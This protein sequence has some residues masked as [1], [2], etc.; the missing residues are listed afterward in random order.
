M[1]FTLAI[2]QLS[3]S[4]E[5][6]IRDAIEMIVQ[7]NVRKAMVLTDRIL[8]G[9]SGTKLLDLLKQCGISAS[10]FS[11]IDPNPTVNTVAAAFE[12]F[13]AEQPGILIA[14]G[15]GSVIDTAKAVRILSANPGPLVNY[16]GPHHEL[17]A[18]TMLMAIC[19]TSGTAAE[20]TSNA[21]II[22][23][24]RHVKMVIISHSIIPDIAVNDPVVLRSMPKGTTAATGMDALT[25]A[26]EAYVSKGAHTLTNHSALEAIRIITRWLPA[27]CDDGNNIEAREMMAHGQFLAGMAFNSAGLGCVHS[28]AH[29]PGATHNL[30][31]GVCNAILLPIVE[32][33]NRPAV[34][35]RFARIAEAMGEKGPFANA[36]EGS[37]AAI[38]AIRKLSE[39]VNI[40]KG[41]G[42][43][44]IHESDIEAWIKPALADPCTPCNPRTFT[45]DDVRNLYKLAL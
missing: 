32:E 9:I 5:G 22:D 4:G 23:P 38:A 24:A 10:V 3:L 15:G 36:E 37:K 8:L 35:D 43:L 28:L 17:K 13:K 27:A 41:F 39:R 26:V 30:P 12:Q 21:V 40:P 14:L 25:H 11:D 19:T 31:H 2:P 18:G 45:L 29:Q 34:M 42:S 16:N 20:V 7:R 1:S 33:F 6:A 44:G